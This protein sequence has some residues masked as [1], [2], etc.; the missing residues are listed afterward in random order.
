MWKVRSSLSFRFYGK[1][2]GISGIHKM[3]R[4]WNLCK[5]LSDGRAGSCRQIK[6][7]RN[8]EVL[9]SLKMD[10]KAGAVALNMIQK[11][12]GCVL[13]ATAPSFV[14]NIKEK[15]IWDLRRQT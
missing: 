15:C 8:C 10:N 3:Y 13:N 14:K 4:L 7:I 6:N 12:S 1:S 11:Y 5:S 9:N 2:R